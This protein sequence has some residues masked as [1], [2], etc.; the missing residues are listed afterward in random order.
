M[1]ALMQLLLKFINVSKR[2]WLFF[3]VAG[4]VVC[5][6]SANTLTNLVHLILFICD[7]CGRF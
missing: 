1:L 6:Y 3:S 7:T 4:T 2:D 5:I